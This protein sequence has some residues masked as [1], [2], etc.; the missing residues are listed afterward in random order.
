MRFSFDHSRDV[1]FRNLGAE[2]PRET[3][4][5]RERESGDELVLVHTL[6]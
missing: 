3:G 4:R 1:F 2:E 5:K 6:R